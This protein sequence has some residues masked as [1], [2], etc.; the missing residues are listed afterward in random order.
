MNGENI[1]LMNGIRTKHVTWNGARAGIPYL[2]DLLQCHSY[3][4]ICIQ[5]LLWT[6]TSVDFCRTTRRH[7]PEH[8]TLHTI[9]F[10]THVNTRDTCMVST[11]YIT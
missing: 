8:R 6:E 11:G 9:P 5:L 10:V 1:I 4:I 3:H 2:S 7:N